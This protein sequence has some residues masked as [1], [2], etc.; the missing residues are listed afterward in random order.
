MCC[1]ICQVVFIVPSFIIACVASLAFS[2]F[3]C[4][5]VSIWIGFDARPCTTPGDSFTYTVVV[6]KGCSCNTDFACSVVLIG[7]SCILFFTSATFLDTYTVIRSRCSVRSCRGSCC[8]RDDV[9]CEPVWW[10]KR[11]SR[12]AVERC[13]CANAV[14]V[15]WTDVERLGGVLA[16]LFGSSIQAAVGALLNT[17]AAIVQRVG[18]IGERRCIVAKKRPTIYLLQRRPIV[19]ETVREVRVRGRRWG[20]C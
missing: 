17:V 9:V 6:G 12:G 4:S 3:L 20:C 11:S 13:R 1:T 8:C 19:A 2:V 18:R 14:F 10:I 7:W 5:W 16:W 15:D